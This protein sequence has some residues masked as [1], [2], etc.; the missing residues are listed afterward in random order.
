MFANNLAATDM[1]T[2]VCEEKD[3]HLE[4]QTLQEL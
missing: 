4:L 3:A 1:F 2:V